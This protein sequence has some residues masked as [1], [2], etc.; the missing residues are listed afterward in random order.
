MKQKIYLGG[1]TSKE[2]KG[3]AT[4]ILDTEAK[5]LENYELLTEIGKPTYL[6]VKE[7]GIY[8]CMQ[9][10]EHGGMAKI[11]DGEVV[12]TCDL[13]EG[14]PCHI[15]YDAT[16]ECFYLSNYHAGVLSVVQEKDGKLIETDRILHHGSSVHPN[17][18]K[19]HIH[20]AQVTPCG[21]YVLVCDLGTDEVYTYEVQTGERITL[22][23]VG[24]FK[25][26]LGFGPRHLT[27]HPAKPIVYVLGELSNEVLV[28]SVNTESGEFTLE[29]KIST[30]PDDFTEF[31]AGAAIRISRD[32]RFLYASNRGYH[33]IAVYKVLDNGM[34]E[35]VEITPSQGD[36]PRDFD[37]SPE[38]DFLVVSHQKSGD[39]TLFAR[40]EETGKLR[41]LQEGVHAPECVCV[42]FEKE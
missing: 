29:Q 39:L 25:T 19:S 7:N 37:F 23:E 10:G 20:F 11:V 3:I 6:L 9:E 12:A 4:I 41:L 32:G 22:K 16:N 35:L 42:H 15:S 13:G 33:S 36:F 2:N 38:E 34:L 14:S 31:S 8:T 1:Y 30:I 24:S 40:N 18:E 17:Q 28:L 27:Y 26:P 21:E 5:R